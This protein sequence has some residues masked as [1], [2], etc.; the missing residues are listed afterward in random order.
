MRLRWPSRIAVQIGL[1][2]TAAVIMSHVVVLVVLVRIIPVLPPAMPTGLMPLTTVIGKLEAAPPGQRAAIIAAAEAA[3]LGFSLRA[4]P[5]VPAPGRPSP[6]DLAELTKALPPGVTLVP[7][8]P[9]G[10]PP[11][12]LGI[13][14]SDGSSFV[15]TPSADGFRR[16]SPWIAWTP[17]VVA[18]TFL[19]VNL[20]LLLLWATRVLTAP[21]TR[22]ARSAED[23]SIDRNPE[24]LPETG[25]DEVRVA[26]QALNRL[27]ARIRAMVDDRT[28]M[29]AAIG[30]DLRT[31]I[32]RMR[33]RA[34]FVGDEPVRDQLVRDL[35]Q[36]DAMVHSA[37]AYLRD[38][39]LTGRREPVDLPSLLRT[40]C[41][42]FADMGRDVA[43]GE[44]EPVIA[45]AD[46]DA[47]MRALTNLVENAVKYAGAAE[48][49]LRRAGDQALIVVAD[50]GPGIGADAREA[51]MEP[52][53]RG[54][55]ARDRNAD[56]PGA[57]AG[58]GLGLSIALAIAEAHGG[59]LRLEENRPRGLRAV[60][61]LPLEPAPA[62]IV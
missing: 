15:A 60:I 48:L 52:F 32:T 58:F 46:A 4:G 53:A 10:V 61:A 5:V 54:D 57:P 41:D 24:P 33:L 38:G 39:R 13:I 51:L 40:V 2:A 27:T 14:L 22:F 56:D 3:G 35:D 28:R 6:P 9:P 23:F 26:A 16:G 1:V 31:P 21:L 36:M 30:H 44:T 43:L 55:E 49:S 45:Q 62:G 12:Q 19:A 47:L 20:A 8:G 18:V 50:E 37:L 11:A 42:L 7:D 34:E 59:E 25:P 17:I 29:L